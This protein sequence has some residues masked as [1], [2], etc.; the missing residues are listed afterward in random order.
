MHRL[1][2]HIKTDHDVD[3]FSS[4]IISNFRK[5]REY[6]RNWRNMCPQEFLLEEQLWTQMIVHCCLQ[7]C[8][9]NGGLYWAHPSN[10][11]V[12]QES[13]DSMVLLEGLRQ[14]ENLS[15]NPVFGSFHN[16]SVSGFIIYGNGDNTAYLTDC[17]SLG[18]AAWPGLG[19]ELQRCQF[20]SPV[21]L[22]SFS[23]INISYKTHLCHLKWPC[24]MFLL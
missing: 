2:F 10:K 3:I 21:P 13:K 20:P 11:N 17:S 15:S 23:L 16:L 9:N 7:I 6:I 19:Q 22:S 1:L 24:L 14:S 5:Q 4:G 18:S 12:E 8:M